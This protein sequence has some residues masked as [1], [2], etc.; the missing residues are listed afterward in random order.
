MTGSLILNEN[1]LSST[2]IFNASTTPGPYNTFT[3]NLRG[4]NLTG[5]KIGLKKLTMYYSWPNITA[6]TNTTISWPVGTGYT[7]FTWNLPA[8]TNYKSAQVLNEALQAFCITNG[9]YLIN[10]TTGD[11]LYYIAIAANETTYKLDLVLSKVPTSLPAGYTQPSNFAGYPTA[12]KTMKF[13]LPTGSQLCD[14]MGFSANTYNGNTSATTFSSNYV[15][16]F[17][18]VSS[19]YVT[20]NLVKN[21]LPINGSTVISVFT[22]RNTEYGSIIELQN[23][24]QIDFYEVDTNSNTV[25][26]Q[27]YDQS[28]NLLQVQDPQTTIHLVVA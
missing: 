23:Q 24:D 4:F 8:N 20:C 11:Y 25:V 17:S 28:W 21:D 13:T 12:S 10:S 14:I 3:T 9:M 16:Q 18:P 22:T 1:N 5:R 26:V 27:F 19:V 2:G 7:D 6:S 15:P